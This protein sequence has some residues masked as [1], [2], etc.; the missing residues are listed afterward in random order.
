MP[1]IAYPARASVGQ[2]DGAMQ[3]VEAINLLD[4]SS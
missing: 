3:G 2:L 4:W 1:D